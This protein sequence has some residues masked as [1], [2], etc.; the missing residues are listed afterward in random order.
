MQAESL[1]K[2]RFAVLGL[3]LALVLVVV[4]MMGS[5]QDKGVVWPTN[6]K[7]TQTKKIV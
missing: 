1:T 6:D 5:D 4:V 2:R 7:A 3:A